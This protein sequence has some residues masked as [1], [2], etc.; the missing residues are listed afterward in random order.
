MAEMRY[1]AD[2]KQ[3]L[4]LCLADHRS[5][6]SYKDQAYL[7]ASSAS[8]SSNRFNMETHKSSDWNIIYISDMR[9]IVKCLRNR[10]QKSQMSTYMMATN[11]QF[12]RI[13]YLYGCYF[14]Q[15][16]WLCELLVILFWIHKIKIIRAN[17][18]WDECYQFKPTKCPR[19]S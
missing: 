16:W 17:F 15:N 13:W 11:M 19:G 7:W 8:G 5:Y 10:I 14:P 4:K 9:K 6:N 2:M 18:K 3:I 1:I 12:T